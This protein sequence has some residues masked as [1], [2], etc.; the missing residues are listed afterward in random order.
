MKKNG[1]VLRQE[2]TR[3]KILEGAQS[4][5][6]EM[7]FKDATVT[8]IAKQAGVGYGSVYV[9]FPS[10]KEDVFLTIMETVMTEFYSVAEISYTPRTVEE[11]IRF[12]TGNIQNYLELAIKYK[13]WVAIFYEAIGQSIAVR[14]K[15]EQI[16]DKFIGRISKN[17]DKVKEL[18]LAQNPEY[19]SKIIAGTLYYPG[20]H[21]LWEIALGHETKDYRSIAENIAQLYNYGLYK[22]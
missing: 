21:F 6:L 18:G 19:D 22:R 11:A 13:T 17:V 12:T 8:Q 5:F 10:G 2:R 16:S 7:G 9:H 4:V 14:K 20:E 15:W 3:E 1:Y